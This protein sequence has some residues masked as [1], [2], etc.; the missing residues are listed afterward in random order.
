ML[1]RAWLAAIA[2]GV[3]ALS[4][5]SSAQSPE[6]AKPNQPESQGQNSGGDGRAAPFSVPVRILEQPEESESAKLEKEVAAKREVEDLLAQQSMANLTEQIVFWTKLQF[7]LGVGGTIALLYMFHLTR[8]A[9]KAAE[10]AVDIT[11]QIGQSEIRAY[12]A[13]TSGKYEIDHRKIL[14]GFTVQNSGPTLP[15]ILS[16]PLGSTCFGQSKRR[17]ARSS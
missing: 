7:A 17:V 5:S 9:T 13:V 1:S 16:V 3:A 15:A 6:K 2:F 11:R 8:K 10:A 12:L 4:G 14:C